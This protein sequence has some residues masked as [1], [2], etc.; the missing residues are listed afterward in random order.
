MV[1]YLPNG[2]PQTP[3]HQSLIRSPFYYFFRYYF[4]VNTG[5][6]FPSPNLRCHAGC[7]HLSLILSGSS[8]TLPSTKPWIPCNTR[9]A[10]EPIIR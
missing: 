7:V 3:N 2:N 4:P 6:A 8:F 1:S 10:E 5:P 9:Y